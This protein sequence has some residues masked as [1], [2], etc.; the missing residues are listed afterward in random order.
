MAKPGTKAEQLVWKMSAAFDY[1]GD[2]NRDLIGDSLFP[3]VEVTE[4]LMV[5]FCYQF[6]CSYIY[7]NADMINSNL[8]G[9]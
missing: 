4:E 2:N 3:M 9:V 5:Q 6:L 8:K 7:R 1:T